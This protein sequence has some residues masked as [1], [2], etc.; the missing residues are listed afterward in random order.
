VITVHRTTVF[1]SVTGLAVLGGPVIGGAIAQ[2]IGWQ[3]IFWL[4][5]PIGL[6]AILEPYDGIYWRT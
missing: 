5:V 2:G 3:W 1:S 4:N 6:L